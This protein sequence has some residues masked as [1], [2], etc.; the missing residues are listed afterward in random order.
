MGLLTAASSGQCNPAHGN[1]TFDRR[2]SLRSRMHTNPGLDLLES[3]DVDG[4]LQIWRRRLVQA[5]AGSQT[6]LK[7]WLHKRV[8]CT[9]AKYHR[10]PVAAQFVSRCVEI[11]P[12]RAW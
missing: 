7:L 5:N 9:A 8:A 10:W 3:G 12:E 6:T 4:G 1:P 2:R 11:Q